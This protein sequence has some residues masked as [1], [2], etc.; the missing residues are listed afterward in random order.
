M[1]GG[2]ADD[3]PAAARWRELSGNGVPGRACWHTGLVGSCLCVRSA[4]VVDG[5]G[6]ALPRADG[7]AAPSPGS[8]PLLCRPHFVVPW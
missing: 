1:G 8:F 2:D 6:C 5:G 7:A 4:T 3:M